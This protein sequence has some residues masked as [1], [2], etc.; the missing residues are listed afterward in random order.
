MQ[1]LATSFVLQCCPG[2]PLVG[3]TVSREGTSRKGSFLAEAEK[4]KGGRKSR[5]QG[6]YHENTVLFLK[7]RERSSKEKELR[8][9][10][11]RR[12]FRLPG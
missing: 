3:H 6:S 5:N 10:Q 9:R 1:Q 7:R 11:R 8:Q 4:K 12:R 2:L